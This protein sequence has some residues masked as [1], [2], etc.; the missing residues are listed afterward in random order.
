MQRHRHEQV[1]IGEE[2]RAHPAHP[3]AEG[4]RAMQAIAVL[5]GQDEP[6]AAVVVAQGRARPV[7]GGRR[8]SAGTAKRARAQLVRK[9]E[10]AAGAA[11]LAQ[12]RDVAPA[13]GAERIGRFDLLRAS[14]T[15]RRQHDVEERATGALEGGVSEREHAP[16]WERE[17]ASLSMRRAIASPIADALY[18]AMAE[19]ELLV[20]DRRAVRQHRERA[21]RL[22]TAEFLFEEAAER[23]AERLGD[24]KRGFARA[25]VL[26]ARRGAM[27]HSLRSSAGFE[28]VIE[29]DDAP[30]FLRR[31]AAT[32]RVAAEAEALPFAA[33]AFDLVVSPLALHWTNDLP[34]ALLQLRRCL[35]PDGLLLASM[36]GGETLH[37]LRGAFL[38][39]ELA[40][41]GGVSPRV[42]PTADGRDL[43]GLL[44]RA[45]FALPVVDTD[46]IPVT[47]PNALALMAEL[48][49]MG[50][51]N[52]LRE[53][54]RRFTRRTTLLRAAEAY[55]A[56]AGTPDGRVAARFEI[57]TMTAWAPHQSQ[58]KPLRPGS[59]AARLADALGTVERP[60]G[61]KAGR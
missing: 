39:A 47:Y 61:D 49:A 42:S 29:A 5:E 60:A 36:L 26:G 22:G 45:G 34:G 59:A 43:A 6:P 19:D 48:R 21:A 37:E 38:E 56:L 14:E 31:P 28:I 51:T 55:R 58:P 46:R 20:F 35:K 24:I 23:L 41:E 16:R 11:R 54:R 53:R 3:F 40:E 4:G 17:P 10:A 7:V 52:A 8:L 30:G 27:A 25:L 9:G 1:G 50:E 2:G 44:Q 32:P 33:E 13:D 18:G 15:A 12:E 57:V